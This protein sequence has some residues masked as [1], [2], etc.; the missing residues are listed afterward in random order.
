MHRFFAF[1]DAHPWAR[2]AGIAGCILATAAIE[3][4]TFPFV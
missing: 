1:L 4:S 2:W 3:G